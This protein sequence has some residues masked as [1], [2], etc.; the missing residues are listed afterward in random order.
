MK[1]KM[2]AFS[3]NVSGPHRRPS[4]GNVIGGCCIAKAFFHYL[5]SISLMTIG[6][7]RYIGAAFFVPEEPCQ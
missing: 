2:T 5:A 3:P 4:R 7:N 1:P 6:K